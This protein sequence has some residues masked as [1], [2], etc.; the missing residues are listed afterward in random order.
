MSFGLCNGPNTF[1]RLMNQVL[2]P[3]TN[4]FIVVYF[5]DILVYSKSELEHLNHL[6]VVLETLKANKLFLNLKKCEFMTNKL[7]FLGY[8]I[9]E[10]GIQMDEQK[11]KAIK[12]WPKPATIY[13]VCSFH[14]LATFY[15]KFIHGFS[16]IYALITECIKKGKFYR[17]K[18]QTTRFNLVK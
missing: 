17:S 9:G 16:L 13:E 8:I 5:N 10:H 7:L 12:E 3:Y 1:M 6:R 18:E 15:R 2:K 11:V 14:G 4:S